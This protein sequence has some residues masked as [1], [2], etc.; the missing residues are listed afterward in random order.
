MNDLFTVQVRRS[1]GVAGISRAGVLELHVH[2][3]PP[4]D[5]PW[6]RLALGAL[7]QLRRLD[8]EEDAGQVRDAFNWFLSIDGEDH[9]VPDSLLTGPARLLAEHVIKTAH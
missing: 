7:E 6:V 1:G 3:S 5:E 4:E 8:A 2:D 9:R